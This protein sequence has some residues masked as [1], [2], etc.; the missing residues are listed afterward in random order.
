MRSV[1][2]KSTMGAVT[3]WRYVPRGRC[4]DLLSIYIGA[5]C[6]KVDRGGESDK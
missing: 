2:I 5:S 4:N 3:K 6:P 1:M